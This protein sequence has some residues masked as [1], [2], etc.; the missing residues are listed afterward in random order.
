MTVGHAA[1]SF[2]N[3]RGTA[4]ARSAEAMLRSLGGEEVQLRYATTA[5]DAQADA[6]LGLAETGSQDAA[7]SPVVV[8]RVAA[9][10][11]YPN[12]IEMLFAA[13]SVEKQ[14]ELRSLDSAD[15]LFGAAIAVVHRGRAYR[16]TSL[17]I[18]YYGG[19]P[20]LYRVT[21]TE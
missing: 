16:I 4:L 18:E 21:V 17:A 19:A 9:G 5:T 13:S 8:R 15:A 20:Y 10:N 14:M 2:N 12:N 1:F 7:I 11:A 6:R 3:D